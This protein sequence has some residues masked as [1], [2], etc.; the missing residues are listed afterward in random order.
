MGLIP[1][2]KDNVTSILA[3]M[4][5]AGFSAEETV[6]LLI[7]HSVAAQHEVDT[8]GFN[9]RSTLGPVRINI[10]LSRRC[11]VLLWILLLVLSTRS[12]SLM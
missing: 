7:S 11:L 1:E 10:R 3:R 9:L 6:D 12:S 4:S 8:V 2:P 5:D